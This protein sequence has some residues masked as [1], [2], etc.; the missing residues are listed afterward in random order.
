[1]KVNDIPVIAFIDNGSSDCTITAIT[2]IATGLKIERIESDLFGFGENNSVKSPGIARVDLEVDN[3]R[4]QGIIMRVVPDNVQK[5]PVIVGRTFTELPH[6]AYEKIGEKFEFREVSAE[7]PSEAAETVITSNRPVSARTENL[8]P[9]NINFIDVRVG[10]K[11]WPM[12]V[13]SLGPSK[14]REN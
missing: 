4:G 12:S 3:V 7:L 11:K 5:W 14:V 10:E 6:I 13:L 8:E 9:G 2:A 1:M